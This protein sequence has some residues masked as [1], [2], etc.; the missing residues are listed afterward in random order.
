MP[1]TMAI[2]GKE[3]TVQKVGGTASV[4]QHLNEIGFNIGSL[5][6]VV[7]SLNGNIIVKVKESRFALDAAMANKILCN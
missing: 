1:L 6:T 7:S 3:V 5:V 4:K 2:P